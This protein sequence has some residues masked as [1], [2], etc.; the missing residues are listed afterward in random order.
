MKLFKELIGMSFTAYLINYRLELAAKQLQE[1]KQ[2]VIDI[3][4]NCGFNNHSYF[5]RS[6]MK[7][8]GCTP[9]KYR[10]ICNESVNT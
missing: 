10:K 6:F 1:S 5:T 4:V 3:A 7:K 9:A 2:K 8:Y